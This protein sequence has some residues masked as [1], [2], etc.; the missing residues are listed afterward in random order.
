MLDWLHLLDAGGRQREHVSRL[1]FGVRRDCSCFFVLREVVVEESVS[2]LLGLPAVHICEVR[3]GLRKL[4]FRLEKKLLRV[5]PDHLLVFR[6]LVPNHELLLRL[7]SGESR[8]DH[9]LVARSTR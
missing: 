3:L 7:G 9:V 4:R 5:G 2:V 1:V 8:F 6:K